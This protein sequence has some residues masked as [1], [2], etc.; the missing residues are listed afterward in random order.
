MT[1]KEKIKEVRPECI[2]KDFDG[3]VEKCPHNYPET[4]DHYSKLECGGEIWY[5]EKSQCE[6]CWNQEYNPSGENKAE[7]E[8]EQVDHPAHYIQPG[9]RECI[10]EMRIVFGDDAVRQW[11]IMTAYKY[12][13]RAGNKENNSA[14]QDHSKAEWYLDYATELPKSSE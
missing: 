4:R 7:S 9:R 13:Y 2:N 11:C 1:L 3:G 5:R 14:E 10:E 6:R 12:R 8:P